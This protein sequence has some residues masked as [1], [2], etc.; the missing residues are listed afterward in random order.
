MCVAKNE[1]LT[2]MIQ[3]NPKCIAS[4]Y[5]KGHMPSSSKHSIMNTKKSWQV[6]ILYSKR[7]HIKATSAG[8]T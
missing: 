5:V 8:H 6:N 7:P 3:D 2:S 1:P 4:Y